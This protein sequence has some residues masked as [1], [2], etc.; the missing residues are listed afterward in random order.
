MSW[1]G[2]SQERSP[3]LFSQQRR[4]WFFHK[5]IIFLPRMLG[6]L[7]CHGDSSHVLA[8]SLADLLLVPL[9]GPDL[10]LARDWG[11]TPGDPGIAWQG[12]AGDSLEQTSG[13]KCRIRD[14]SVHAGA[15][16]CSI[17]RRTSR[18]E[19]TARVHKEFQHV[20]VIERSWFGAE[21][22]VTFEIK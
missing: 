21:E 19:E 4:R 7:T 18:R 1:S 2:R 6:W 12:R 8:L 10:T 13:S 20:R 17:D 15:E 11:A 14:V 5:S 22:S 16:P 3:W 9:P